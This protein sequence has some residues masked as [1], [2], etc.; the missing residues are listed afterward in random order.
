MYIMAISRASAIPTIDCE[1]VVLRT[2]GSPD[3]G[4]ALDTATQVSV[5]V[6]TETTEGVKLVIKNKLRA[7]KMEQ[8]TITGNQITLTDNVFTPELVKILQGGTI[9]TSEGGKIT[10]YK[11][12]KSGSGES[13]ETFELDLYSAVYDSAGTIVNY[14]KTTYP[15]CKGTP[16]AFGV[17]DNTFRAPEYVINSAPKNGEEPYTISYVES[18]PDIT[19]PSVSSS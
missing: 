5:A 18:L 6:Q 3:T 4:Y 9:A 12:P 15:N 19:E 10:G 14:E 8:S 2:S 17:Q 11:P 13:G 7:Q 16:V 1:L